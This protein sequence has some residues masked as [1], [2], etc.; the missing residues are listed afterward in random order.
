M[1]VD[2]YW[3]AEGWGPLYADPREVVG[4]P[5]IV[6]MA[7]IPLVDVAVDVWI[8]PRCP[9]VAQISSGSSVLRLSE[10]PKIF[11]VLKMVQVS[12]F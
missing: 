5:E 10:A 1:E 7:L 4:A 3:L 11:N 8:K 6:C 12:E 9:G 2:P